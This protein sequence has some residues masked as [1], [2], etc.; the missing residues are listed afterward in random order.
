M[1]S[2]SL[3]YIVKYKVAENSQFKYIKIALKDRI[4]ILYYSGFFPPLVVL[5]FNIIQLTNKSIFKT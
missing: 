1:Y 4:Y 2:I 5:I 3:S